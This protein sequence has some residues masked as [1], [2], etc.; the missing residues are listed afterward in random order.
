MT[1][2]LNTKIYVCVGGTSDQNNGYN[3]GTGRGTTWGGGGGCTS[4]T[5]N[6][7]G[8]LKNFEN[9][10]SEV[11]LVAGGAGGVDYGGIGG[12]GGGATGGSGYAND[13]KTILTTGGTQTNGGTGTFN[14][15]FGQGANYQSGTDGCAGGGGGWYGGAGP[16]WR[17]PGGA[18]GGSGYINQTYISNGNMLNGIKSGSGSA[19]ISWHPNI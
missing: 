11:L 16:E 3:G 2:T 1:I 10:K 12:H 9:H 6:N 19:I 18:G 14:G 7:R 4:Y 8:V 5:L 17:Q 15:S 13:L